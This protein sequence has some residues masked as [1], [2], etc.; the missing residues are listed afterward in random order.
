[1][2]AVCDTASLMTL[3]THK[4]FA[5]RSTSLIQRRIFH[6]Q[7]ESGKN[8]A[9][10]FRQMLNE[11]RLN[12][13]HGETQMRNQVRKW[14]LMI[15]VQAVAAIVLANFTFAVS[16]NETRHLAD[17]EKAKVSG[18]ILSRDGDL[19]RLRDKKS[20]DLILVRIRRS[21]QNRAR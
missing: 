5:R 6:K 1:M 11:T 8:L 12:C 17:G 16:A 9:Y 19:V 10:L 15:L 2:T 20:N 14:K 3:P 4:P 7:S 21:H 13:S 18:P